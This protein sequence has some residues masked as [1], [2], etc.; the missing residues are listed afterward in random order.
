MS[1]ITYNPNLHET[2]EDTTH[3]QDKKD[4]GDRLCDDI[5]VGLKQ[6]WLRTRMQGKRALSGWEDR[7]S[8]QRN[9]DCIK[10]PNRNLRTEKYSVQIKYENFTEWS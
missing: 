9:R 4:S 6:L 3:Y 7:S 5:D 10:E 8:Q 2:Q 1:K